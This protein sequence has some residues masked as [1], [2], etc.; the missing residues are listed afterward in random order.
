VESGFNHPKETL[1]AGD[2]N[3]DPEATQ[4]GIVKVVAL[5]SGFRLADGN[6]SEGFVE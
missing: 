5:L 3:A 2:R 4:C 6:I 1:G